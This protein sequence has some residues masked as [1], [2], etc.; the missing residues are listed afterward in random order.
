MLCCYRGRSSETIF[1]FSDDLVN[2]KINHFPL[3]G[4]EGRKKRRHRVACCFAWFRHVLTESH[5]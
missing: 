4:M 1:C 3:Y 5:L 2:V